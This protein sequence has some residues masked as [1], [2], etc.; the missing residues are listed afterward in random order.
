VD[1]RASA[2]QESGDIVPGLGEGRFAHS[3]VAAELGEVV[4]GGVPGRTSEAQI[5]VF[6]SLGLAVEDLAAAHLAYQRA[7]GCGKGVAIDLGG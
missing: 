3:H 4:S 6:K 1:S 5:T 7:R 2:F